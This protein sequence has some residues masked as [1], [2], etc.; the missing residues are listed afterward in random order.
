MLPH[1]AVG[2]KLSLPNIAIEKITFELNLKIIGKHE[3]FLK[4]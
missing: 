2:K 4:G 3:I 1:D